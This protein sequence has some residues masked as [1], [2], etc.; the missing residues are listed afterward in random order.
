VLDNSR[1]VEKLVAAARLTKGSFVCSQLLLLSNELFA[2]LSTSEHGG[3]SAE[4]S[5]LVADDYQG[6]YQR[7]IEHN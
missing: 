3:N 7:E 5:V 2:H 6:E 1:S 4:F